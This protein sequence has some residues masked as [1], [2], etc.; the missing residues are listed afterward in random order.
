MKN[1]PVCKENASNVF[2][3]EREQYHEIQDLKAQMQ[4]KNMVINEL[5]KTHNSGNKRESLWKPIVLYSSYS[6]V[7]ILD[8]QS[9]MTDANLKLLCNFVEKFLGTV[10]FGNDQ[11][12]PILGY[13]DLIQG[14]VTIKRVYYVEGLNHNLFS[15]GQFCDADLEKTTSST[16]IC[17]MI[18]AFFTNSTMVYAS[19]AFSSELRLPSLTAQTKELMNIIFSFDRLK[20]WALVT[21][22]RQKIIKQSGYGRT[23][24]KRSDCNIQQSTTVSKGYA[25]GRGGGFMLRSRPEWSIVDPR[26]SEQVYLKETLYGLKQDLQEPVR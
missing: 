8:A 18:K 16:P 3:K 5:K 17:F 26:S 21:N 6:F 25:P 12:A 2:R 7:D 24:R 1:N 23:R 4:D 10:H 9:H 22:I 20:F 13:G 19:K 11:F 15:V 14:N